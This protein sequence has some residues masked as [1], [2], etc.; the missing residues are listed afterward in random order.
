MEKW[1]DKDS[2]RA[3]LIAFIMA[4]KH[5]TRIDTFHRR[6]T[7]LEKLNYPCQFPRHLKIII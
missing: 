6:S 4:W 3:F 2:K 5:S 1:R 7:D